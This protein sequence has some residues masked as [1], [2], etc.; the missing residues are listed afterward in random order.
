MR[1]PSV[2][3]LRLPP[4]PHRPLT[5]TFFPPNNTCAQDLVRGGHWSDRSESDPAA[6]HSLTLGIIYVIDSRQLIRSFPS[7]SSPALDSM[8]STNLNPR[9]WPTHARIR[10][11]SP[12]SLNPR[13]LGVRTMRYMGGVVASCHAFSGLTQDLNAQTESASQAHHASL[14]DAAP[15]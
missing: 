11:P 1:Y 10:S 2:N 3:V 4:C 8:P 12:S 14:T 9:Y 5:T 15:R 7:V 13:R 6:V